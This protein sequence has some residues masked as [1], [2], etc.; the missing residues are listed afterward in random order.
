MLHYIIISN[1][2]FYLH[3]IYSGYFFIDSLQWLRSSW[4]VTN[5]YNTNSCVCMLVLSL[6]AL[7]FYSVLSSFI[8]SIF[9]VNS[10]NAL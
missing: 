1:T 10:A 6:I 5:I 4:I 7:F 8:L 9:F 3:W 2:T